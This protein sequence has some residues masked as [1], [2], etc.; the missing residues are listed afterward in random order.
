[1]LRFAVV[2]LA[3]TVMY[4]GVFLLLRGV[5]AAGS[6]G[7]GLLARL[8]VAWPTSWWNARWTLGSRMSLL[9]AY[10]AGLGGLVLGAALSAVALLLLHP[11]APD[12]RA[13]VEAAVLAVTQVLAATVRFALLRLAALTADPQPGDTPHQTPARRV[14]SSEER[15]TSLLLPAGAH[16]VCAAGCPCPSP[17]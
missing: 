16:H 3:G 11:V 1:M 9:R 12:P 2:G 7:A 15:G 8:L 6:Q 4:V 14:I 13:G 10:A 17:V 5:T